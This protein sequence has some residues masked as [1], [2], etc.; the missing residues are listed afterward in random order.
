MHVGLQIHYSTQLQ[1]NIAIITT[2]KYIYTST[3]CV[4]NYIHIYFVILC[5]YVYDYLYYNLQV[6]TY[7]CAEYYSYLWLTQEM[8]VTTCI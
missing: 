8:L 7:N 6:H 1:I 5:L 3:M 4:A 2:N